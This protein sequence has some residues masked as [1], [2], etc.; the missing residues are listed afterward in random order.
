MLLGRLGS[1]HALEQTRSCRGVWRR[2][3]GEDVALPS[4]DT[5]ARVQALLDPDAIRE[6]LASFYAQLRRN[7]ALP[8]PGHGL[9]ALVLD[10]H[11]TTASYRRCCAGCLRREITTGTTTRT[12]YYHRYVL[13]QLAADHAQ[14]LLDAEPQR[15]GED[16]VAAAIRLLERVT[17]RC[18]RAFDVVLADALYARTAFVRKV[19]ALGKD[20]VIV[21]KQ[22]AWDLTR[23]VEA[24]SALLPAQELLVGSRRVQC[25]DLTGLAWKGYEGTVRAVRSLEVSRTRRQL[26]K[27][28]EETQTSWIWLATL[29]KARASTRVVHALGHRRWAIENE[30]FNEA[31]GA[32]HLDHV[33]HHEPQAMLVMLL[34]VLLAFNLL[35][36]FYDRN[37]KP[38]VRARATLQHVGRQITAELY[39]EAARPRAP[40]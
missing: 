19:R 13:A 25:W 40:P 30:G 9:L 27:T 7:K 22:E 26:T 21:L 3:L 39:T 1:L 5:L 31:V 4:A 11:E 16:E 33:Y 18:P 29:D 32:W 17:R 2:V 36:V 10:G 8:A 14:L 35:H 6:L 20:A 28:L 24:L 38:A 15:P 37:L 34:L 23:E 12:Q